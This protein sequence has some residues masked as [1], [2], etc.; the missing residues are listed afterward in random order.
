[1]VF[2][3]VFSPS[4]VLTLITLLP[5][6]SIL[7]CLEYVLKYACITIKYVV[8]VFYIYIHFSVQQTFHSQLFSLHTVVWDLLYCL[9]CS[10]ARGFLLMLSSLLC[11]FTTCY[12][13]I[14]LVMGHRHLRMPPAPLSA[15]A[16]SGWAEHGLRLYR[17]CVF[18]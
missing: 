12:S 1:M 17:R 16:P 7:M 3:C 14:P 11:V 10:Q 5:N 8:Y 18:D 2:L 4:P 13:S 9:R 6:T 15:L